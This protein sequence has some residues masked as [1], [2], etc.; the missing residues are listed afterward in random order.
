MQLNLPFDELHLDT[1]TPIC[2]CAN[3]GKVVVKNESVSSNTHDFCTLAC[4][5]VYYNSE[6]HAD[7]PMQVNL[8][9]SLSPYMRRP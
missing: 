6:H 4:R 9:Y 2:Y 7:R 1:Y 3:C 5:S 8:R